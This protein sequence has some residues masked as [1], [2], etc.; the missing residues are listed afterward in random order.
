MAHKKYVDMIVRCY[1]DGRI[2]PLAV[3][4]SE[5][6]LYEIDRVLDVR[7]AVSLKAGG[8]GTRYT[9]RIQ[10]HETCVWLE[11]SRW[12]VEAKDRLENRNAG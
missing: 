1:P 4:W 8:A 7:P 9:C 6:C 10:G 12:F 2:L 3:Y 11:G 5:G